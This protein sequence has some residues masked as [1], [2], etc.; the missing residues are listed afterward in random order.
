MEVFVL[1]AASFLARDR[2][3]DVSQ[4]RGPMRDVYSQGPMRG[5]Y[6]N[7]GLTMGDH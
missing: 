7:I 2:R 5:V 1:V 3:L 4:S 6:H